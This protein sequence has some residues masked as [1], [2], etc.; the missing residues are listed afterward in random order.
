[1]TSLAPIQSTTNVTSL[2]DHRAPTF[3]NQENIFNEIRQQLLPHINQKGGMKAIS[4]QCGGSPTVQTI[5]RIYYGETRLPRWGTIVALANVL[6]YQ[7]GLY[8]SIP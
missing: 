6:G 7:V 8:R 1:M 3:I 5:S 2:S 4:E